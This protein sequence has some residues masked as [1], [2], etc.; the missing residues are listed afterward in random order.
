MADA[1]R[2]A[3]CYAEARLLA[4]MELAESMRAQIAA[5]QARVTTLE[6]EK[7]SIRLFWHAQQEAM[8]ATV[9]TAAAG[10]TRTVVAAAWVDSV[11]QFEDDV[12]SRLIDAPRKRKSLFSCFARNRG[13]GK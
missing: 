7:A 2:Y 1:W 6:E 11:K 13:T 10:A 8:L 3:D 12:V 9:A 5:L 4:T